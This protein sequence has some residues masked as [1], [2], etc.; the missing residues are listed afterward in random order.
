VTL[1]SN[2]GVAVVEWE[3]SP[4]GDVIADAT[5]ALLMHA[6]SS[7]AS[8][9]LTSKP[10]RHPRASEEDNGQDSTTDVEPASKKPREELT[11]SRL[12]LIR[13]T[14]RDQFETVEAVFEGNT[15]TYEIVTDCGLE[16]GALD[17]N[18]LLTCNAKVT[19][20]GPTGDTAEI[21]VECSDNK[22]ASTVL[23][24]LRNLANALAPL[25]V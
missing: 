25:K 2:K 16:S 12:R 5:I 1:G 10:C 6:Q 22:L 8:I 14:L 20:D 17:D 24:C 21:S 15:A 18:G 23:E 9:R 19:F 4:A 13:D 3:A 11:E 7:A